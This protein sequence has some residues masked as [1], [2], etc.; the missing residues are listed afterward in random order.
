MFAY[1]AICDVLAETLLQVTALLHVHRRAIGT[2]LGRWF[3]WPLKVRPRPAS[4]ILRPYGSRS[5]VRALLH[6]PGPGS[7]PTNPGSEDPTAPVPA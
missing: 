5:L 7:R 2:L 1:S 4:Q 6:E 3:W